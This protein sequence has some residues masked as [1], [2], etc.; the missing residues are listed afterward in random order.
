MRRRIYQEGMKMKIGKIALACLC[1]IFMMA[2]PVCAALTA[3][4]EVVS[5]KV[6]KVQA[7]NVI[8][9]DDGKVYFP[10]KKIA[11]LAGAKAGDVITLK[12]FVQEETKRIFVE[13]APGRDSLPR[14]PRIEQPVPVPRY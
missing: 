5:G 8:T 13:Y 11:D 12:Y 14:S 3:Q 1:G 7:G 4:L 9:L 6:L 2:T 10:G